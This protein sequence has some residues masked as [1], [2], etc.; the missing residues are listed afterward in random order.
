MQKTNS[1]AHDGAE[2]V[3]L[4]FTVSREHA[5]WLEKAA[6]TFGVPA[7]VLVSLAITILQRNFKV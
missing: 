2:T 6:N 3:D 1:I 5:E 7:S 4:T